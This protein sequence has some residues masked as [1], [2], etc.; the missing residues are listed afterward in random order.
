MTHKG[1]ALLGCHCVTLKKIRSHT[2]DVNN[3]NNNPELYSSIINYIKNY[4]YCNKML[5][6][7]GLFVKKI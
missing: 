1:L 6:L 3:I 5:A 2:I 7:V 4:E